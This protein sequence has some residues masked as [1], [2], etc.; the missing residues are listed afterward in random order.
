LKPQRSCNVHSCINASTW[1]S[2]SSSSA[3]LVQPWEEWHSGM[4][5]RLP[6]LSVSWLPSPMRHSFI[7][8]SS[9]IVQPGR[10]RKERKLEKQM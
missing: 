4:P 2:T 7:S 8:A 9:T 5:T 6:N 10:L 3:T 1:M